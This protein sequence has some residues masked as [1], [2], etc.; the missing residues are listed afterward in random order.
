MSNN[1]KNSLMRSKAELLSRSN[2]Q[3]NPISQRDHIKSHC[4]RE[5]Y[6]TFGGAGNAE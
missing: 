2:C 6:E 3:T 1:P 4:L 5:S